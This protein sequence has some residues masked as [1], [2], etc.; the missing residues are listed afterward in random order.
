MIEPSTVIK[1]HLTAESLEELEK[2]ML[3]ANQVLGMAL[4]YGE[5]HQKKDGSFYVSFPVDISLIET[6]DILAPK[7]RVKNAPN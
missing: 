1:K 5:T 6:L 2:L 3:K 7:K 4:S